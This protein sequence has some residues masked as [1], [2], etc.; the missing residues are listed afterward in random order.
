LVDRKIAENDE[1]EEYMSS[2]PKRENFNPPSEVLHI[3]YLPPDLQEE[4]FKRVEEH[5]KIIQHSWQ[6]LTNINKWMLLIKMQSI[7]ESL[8]VMGFLQNVK[9]GYRNVKISF[10]RSKL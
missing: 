4:F 6:K 3:T 10:T 5:G 1:C 2:Q 7:E 9:I 8:R